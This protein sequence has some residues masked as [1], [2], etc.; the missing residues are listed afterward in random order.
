[1]SYGYFGPK[2][3]FANHNVMFL[4]YNVC[5]TEIRHGFCNHIEKQLFC[6]Y[7][8]F[9]D[10]QRLN[11]MLNLMLWFKFSWRTL[12]V[13][14]FFDAVL[15]LKQNLQTLCPCLTVQVSAILFSFV[16]CYIH[17]CIFK[18]S[19][20]VTSFVDLSVCIDI[21]LSSM[22]VLERNT[23]FSKRNEM[24]GHSTSLLCLALA[25]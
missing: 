1:M 16:C 8:L 9:L 15:K 20:L 12:I 6:I 13:V 14:S 21:M 10:F 23:T 4:T 24:Q 17:I 7:F 25:C 19:S 5:T 11:H 3:I 18:H 2:Q 22:A